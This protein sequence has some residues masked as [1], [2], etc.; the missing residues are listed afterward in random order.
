MRSLRKAI[1]VWITVVLGVVAAGAIV[2]SYHLAREEANSLLD[3]QLRQIAVYAGDLSPPHDLRPAETELEN[4]LI[5]QVW[6]PAGD[7]RVRSPVVDLPRQASPGFS[8]VDYAGQEW[9]VYVLQDEQRVAQVAQR[10]SVREELAGK[11]ALGAA[12]PALAGAPL[13]WLVI[14]LVINRLLRRLGHFTEALAQRSVNA[15]EPID[16]GSIPSEIAPLADA[17]NG[18]IERYQDAVAKQRRFVS[19]AAHALRTPLAAV[20]IQADNLTQWAKDCQAGDALDELAGGVRRASALVNQLLR[21]ARLDDHTDTGSRAEADLGRLVSTVVADHVTIAAQ[22]QVD[23]GLKSSPMTS[24]SVVDEDVR[25]LLSNLVDNAIRYTPHGG[26][27]DLLVEQR[28]RSAVIH[29]VD[30]GRGIP[31]E[32]LPRLFDRFFRAAPE[33][34]GNGLGLAIAKAIADRHGFHLA[35]ANRSGG[36]G[37]IATLTIPA[38]RGSAAA[39]AR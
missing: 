21:I 39:A 22:K 9:R 17:M 31:D 34:E 13:A 10:W 5:V 2:A 26:T 37:T 11:A 38:N 32:A 28:E 35:I 36:V 12:V 14:I 18:L 20:Q 6:G 15:R 27:V 1:L 19:D 30:T 4:E 25:L 33:V 24:V 29:V 3:A 23:L 7:L 8:D 16:P